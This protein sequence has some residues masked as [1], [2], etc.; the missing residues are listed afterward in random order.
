MWEVSTITDA[1]SNLLASWITG[2]ELR[3]TGAAG[4]SG[5]VS[6]ADLY[7]MKA[8]TDPKQAMS[9]VGMT[10]EENGVTIKLQLEAAADAY[11]LQQIGVFAR[12]NGG[13]DV[14][15]TK[16]AYPSQPRVRLSRLSTTSLLPLP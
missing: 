6:A 5:T 3:I 15:L 14:L 10:K 7:T 16:S 11:M 4:G 1:G 13:E 9:L 2:T 8:L 12:I